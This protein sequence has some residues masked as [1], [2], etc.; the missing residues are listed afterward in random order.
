MNLLFSSFFVRLTLLLSLSAIP[1]PGYSQNNSAYEQL[2]KQFRE[3]FLKG[4]LQGKTPGVKNQSK[5]CNCMADSYQA[6]YDGTS[7]ATISQ[8]SLS[9]GDKGPALVNLMVLPEAKA[10][11][12]GN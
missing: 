9:I 11:V 10:C 8:L 3:G 5:Y 1:T 6:R 12:A 4:C 7:L 2:T